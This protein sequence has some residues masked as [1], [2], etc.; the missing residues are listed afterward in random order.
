MLL[1][2]NAGGPSLQ[3]ALVITLTNVFVSQVGS[4]SSQNNVAS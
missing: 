2:H 4:D 1:P 3:Y